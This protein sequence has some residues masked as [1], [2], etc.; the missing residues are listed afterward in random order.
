MK[1]G[2]ILKSYREKNNL[3]T[4]QIVQYLGTGGEVYLKYESG[5]LEP[6]YETLEQLGDLYGV[7][8]YEL[9]TSDEGP[10]NTLLKY[11]DFR[12]RE[13]LNINDLKEIAKIRKRI[14]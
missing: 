3:R 9:K 13:D 2:E 8:I 5:E 12:L 7:S 1:L 11:F 10:L 14:R 6:D 4:D